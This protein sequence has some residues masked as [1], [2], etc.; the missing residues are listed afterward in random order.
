MN[1]LYIWDGDY[2]WD[3]RVDKVCTSLHKNGH[4]LHIVCRNL[5]RKPIKESYKGATIHRLF[6]LPKWLGV[7]NNVLS[8]P[9]FFSPVWLLRIYYVAKNQQCDLIIVRDLPMALAGLLIAKI[10]KV[11]CILDMAECYPEMLRCTWKFEGI[12][13]KNIFI[14]NPALADII[15][16]IVMKYISHVWVMIEES[17]SRLLRLGVE[18][19]KIS[20][21]SNTPI[22]ERF[23]YVEKTKQQ[24]NKYHMIYVG[25]LNPSRGLDTAIDAVFH[26]VQL[27]SKFHFTIVGSGKAETTLKSKVEKLNLQNHVTFLGWVNN[28]KIPNLI[29]TADVGIVPHHNC[30]HWASTIPN[31]LFD[32]MVSGIP[33]IVSDVV[34]MKR[35]V[36]TIDC[37]RV[38]EDYNP[39]NLCDVISELSD[40]ELRQELS[41]RGRSAVEENYNWTKEEKILFSSIDSFE[42]KN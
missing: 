1:I 39:K 26:Y 10:I 22:V 34:P 3:I 35:I 16:R 15:E 21:V 38:Y 18:D 37:G 36:D 28:E 4:K 31:K 23:Q 13:L 19:K 11:P 14:R 33:V 32:Y 40:Q 29:A 5:K 2:P 27:N 12:S 41:K 6:F 42:K 20:I 9:A 17:K 8:F 24:S 7:L 25:L 30:S